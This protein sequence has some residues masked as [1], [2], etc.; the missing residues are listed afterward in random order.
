MHSALSRGA[1]GNLSWTW[2]CWPRPSRC[3]PWPTATWAG[4]RTW[5]RARPHGLPGSYLNGVYESRPLPYAES[6]YGLPESGEEIINVT[7]GKLIRLFVDDELFDV[8]S[9]ELRSHQRLLDFRTGV[10]SRSVDWVSPA[11][12]R[13]RVSSSRMVSFTQRAVAAICYE[14]EPV[15]G[16]ARIGVHSELIANEQL[17]PAQADPRLPAPLE[18]ALGHEYHRRAMDSFLRAAHAQDQEQ[19]P[20]RRCRD[21][22]PHRMPGGGSD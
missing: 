7:N 20:A 15:N 22:S 14:V 18:N 1:C 9:G 12:R 21:G 16:P 11:G 13:V 17:P 8:R 6:A 19:R 10:L 4:A 2:T 5:T 3:S